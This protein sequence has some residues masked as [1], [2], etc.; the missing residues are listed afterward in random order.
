MMNLGEVPGGLVVR[1]QYL[2]LWQPGLVPGLGPEIPHQATVCCS[3]KFF[4]KLKKI[5]FK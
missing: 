4:F 5:F 3:Q 2:R 1:T